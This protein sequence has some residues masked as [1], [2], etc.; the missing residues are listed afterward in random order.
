MIRVLV[1]VRSGATRFTAE[2]QAESIKQAVT[3]A[4]A[5]HPGCEAKVLFP[6]DPEVFFA[7]RDDHALGPNQVESRRHRT[8]SLPRRGG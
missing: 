5:R 3:L 7:E 2:M 6:I 1:E 4:I 8:L